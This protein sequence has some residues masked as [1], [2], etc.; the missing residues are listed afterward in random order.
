MKRLTA[1]CFLAAP[2][3]AIAAPP[4]EDR[5]AILAMSGT[6]D[7]SFQFEEHVVV[8]PDYRPLSPR[9]V[10][11]ALEVVLV[12]EDRPERITLQHLLLVGG[13]EGEP[14]VIKHWAQVW[15]WEDERLL[16]YTGAEGDDAWQRL[17]IEPSE[18]T[19]RWTQ[20]VTS[21]DDT[22]RYESIGRWE[23]HGGE[24]S[25]TGSPC[26]RPLPR[27]E[28]T[29]RD[30]YDYLLATNR[31]TI[32]SDGWVHF[33]D[34]RKV[35]DRGDDVTVL[36]FERGLNRYVRTENPKAET[37]IAWWRE[38]GEV[39]NAVRN[40]MVAAGERDGGEFRIISSHEGTGLNRA[41]RDLVSSGAEA[42]TVGSTLAPYLG[43]N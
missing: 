35:V 27:R 30:D 16:H 41:L 4:A 6:F 3:A 37:A 43:A 24:S 33:Q 26:H 39:W 29:K 12:A 23:H 7:V 31:H 1:L 11:R 34:N 5:A 38:H 40:E 21:V 14:Q 36:S 15:T 10:E 18:A 9:Y 42:E 28:Y 13:D 17:R 20:L 25:W 2:L 19:G 32:T 8:A 22:P